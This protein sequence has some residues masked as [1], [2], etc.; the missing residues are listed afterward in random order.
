M[1]TLEAKIDVMAR[2][3]LGETDAKSEL[4]SLLENSK[5]QSRTELIHEAMKELGVPYGKYGHDYLVEAVG[6]VIDNPALINN[7]TRAHGLYQVL[8]EKVTST[9][10]R[11]ERAIRHSIESMWERGDCDIL[12]HHFGNTIDPNRCK[13]TNTEAIACIASIVRFRMEQGG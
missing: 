13:P 2:I 9:P 8:A 11:V 7:A 4:K 5:K 3:L 12:H 10:S 1:T 6:M